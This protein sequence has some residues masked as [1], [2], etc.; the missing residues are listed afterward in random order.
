M[1]VLVTGGAG[2]IGSH[3]LFKLADAGHEVAAYDNL[4]SGHRWAV[5]D[6][7]FHQGDIND[8]ARL[9]EVLGKGG[10]DAV[11]H[12]AAHIWVGESVRDP[13]KYYRNNT[14]GAFT[15]F[16]AC[17]RHKLKAVVFSSTAA[18]YGEPLKQPIDEDVDKAPI[19]PY[20][21]SKLMAERALIEAAGAYGFAYGI[22]RYFN[23][24]GA[25]PKGRVGEATPE[26]SHLIKVACETA[27]GKRSGMRI[28]GTDYPTPDGTCV[29]DF[30]HI[31]DLA[32]AHL[33]ALEHLLAGKPSLIANCGYGHGYSV[34]EVLDTVRRISGVMF[35][36]EIGERRPGDP[37]SLVADARRIGELLGWTPHHDDLDEIVQSAWNWEQKLAT[38]H[39][40]GRP[41]S[42]A[43]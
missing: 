32:G 14:A 41:T 30:V 26:N 12:C 39:D 11:I 4:Y 33:A 38:G 40:L 35:P 20:G 7:P 2:Y 43:T 34:K 28:N 5:G 23:V 1:R 37:P 15:L 29:R 19:N 6:A 25:D 24:A 21:A 17:A 42:S 13:L 18:V 27:I 31:D 22:L 16:D 9:D 8:Q 3:I 10:F 36:I